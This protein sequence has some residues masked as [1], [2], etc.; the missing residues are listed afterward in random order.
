MGKGA[1]YKRID[2]ILFFDLDRNTLS[3]PQVTFPALFCRGTF[4]NE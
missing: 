3:Y 2:S 4:K 1:E